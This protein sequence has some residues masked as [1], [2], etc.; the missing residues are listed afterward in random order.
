M[1]V[2]EKGTNSTATTPVPVRLASF[3]KRL[4][5]IESIVREILAQAR[6]SVLLTFRG[7][8]EK[9]VFLDFTPTPARILVDGEARTGKA[10]VTVEAEIMQEILLGRMKPGLA[11]GR[12]ELLLRGSAV[13][14][15]K[16]IPLFDFGP[17][18]YREHLADIGIDGFARRTCDAP[19]KEAVMNEQIFKGDAIST[20][21][22]TGLEGALFKVIYALSFLMGAVIGLLRYRVFEKLSLFEALS[23]MSR[24]LAAVTPK[25]EGDSPQ[26]R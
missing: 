9:K 24:G 6:L 5:G 19:L 1:T 26:R 2:K 21:Q 15:S 4:E 8:P 23:A 11:L 12:R 13:D 7:R 14:L 25:A 18:L 22:L 10:M 20:V 17:V 3:F 16:F